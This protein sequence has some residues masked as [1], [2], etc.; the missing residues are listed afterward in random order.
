MNTTPFEVKR[1]FIIK[2]GKALHKFG[3]PAYRLEAHLHNVAKH[4][5]LDGY[6]LI[7][8]TALT[9]V[10]W[11]PGDKQE[12]THVFRVKPGELDLGALARTDELVEDMVEGKY[13]LQQALQRLVIIEQAPNPYNTVTTLFSFGIVGAAFAM[14][15]ATSWNDVFWSFLL[16]FPVYGLV[17]LAER[18]KRMAEMLEPLSA[19]MA[20][21][22]ASG[23]MWLDPAINVPV[24]TLSSIIIFIPGLSLTLGL[25]EL[26]ARDLV[27]GTARIMD[28]MMLLFKL[29]FGAVLG[30][31]VGD[32]IW[33]P[34]SYI[35]EPA[36][37]LWANLLGV[38]L[39]SLGLVVIFKSRLIDAPWGILAGIIAYGF[40]IMG[41]TYLGDA[42]GPFLGAFMVGVYGNLFAR[43]MKAPASI[44]LLPGIVLLV[45][46][47]KTYIGLNT[48]ITGESMVDQAAIGSQTLLIFMSLV[49][50]LI[51]ANVAVSPRRTL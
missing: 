38:P 9:F 36:V 47:S 26:A 30:M 40:S 1:D 5:G 16:S 42:L 8:P 22:C 18:S 6:F 46:G 51:F 20:A 21:F 48:M 17:F 44:A 29:Y 23:L 12:Y 43:I 13:K 34:P 37:P 19:M 35:A 50:G 2:L 10:L 4:V 45:P 49:A 11:V 31:A 25:S 15:I 28:A 7:T 33:Q 39:L 3:T 32:L 27:S 24:V 14:L 41:S